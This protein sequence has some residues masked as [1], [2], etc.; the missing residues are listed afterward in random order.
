MQLRHEQWRIAGARVDGAGDRL[1]VRFP[2]NGALVGTVPLAQP[3]EVQSALTQAYAYRPTLTRHQRHTI[4]STAR[5]LLIAR[6]A[7]FVQSIVSESGLCVRDASYEVGRA[8]EV[9]RAAAHQVLIDDGDIY[10]CD[11]TERGQQRRVY[12]QRDPL[13]GVIVAITPFNHP[14]NQVVHK[15]APSIATNNRMILKP[16][17]K[18]PLTALLFAD[19]LTDAGLPAPM[20]TVMTAKPDVIAEVLLTSE[21]V[22]LVTFTG[23]VA[24]GKQIAARCIYKRQVLEL[25][26]NDPMIVMEDADLDEAVSLAVAGAY[27]NSGQRCTAIK[28]LLVHREIADA[29]VER[30]VQATQRLKVGDPFDPQVDLGTLIDE[31]AAAQIERRVDAAAGAQVLCGH[32]RNGAQYLPTVIDHVMPSMEL[33]QQETF[34]PVAPI[35]R[36]DSIDDAIRIA[37]ASDFG[38]SAALCSNRWDYIQRCVAELQTGSVNIRE[39]PGF[40][41]ESTPF[42]GIKNSGLGYKEGVLEAMSAYTNIKTYSLPWGERTVA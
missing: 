41:L 27:R 18:T 32:R 25:G 37:N 20:L 28:R 15:V 40:R 26:G 14:L 3:E 13:L 16:S 10:A 24:A 36:I 9:L 35:V 4:L 38:L 1:E 33:V 31:A 2:Y 12:T 30:L 34:G 8:A 42:G 39:V 21:Q 29:F 11:I 19:L 7:T 5:D 23:S 6:T 17:E 22:D